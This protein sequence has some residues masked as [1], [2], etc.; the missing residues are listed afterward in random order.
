MRGYSIA[1]GSFTFMIISARAHTSSAVSST[2]APATSYCSSVKPLPSP[3]PRSMKS[4]WPFW[5]SAS[6]PAGTRATRFSLVLISRGTPISMPYPLPFAAAVRHF[7]ER[8]LA[9]EPQPPLLVD[10]QKL[11]VRH[12]ALL[13]HVLRLLGAAVLQLGDVDE[14]LGARH[15]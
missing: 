4:W 6:A 7:G 9:R 12:V 5:T 11:D 10:G 1:M 8:R 13:H 15:D 14:P 3:A 2:V